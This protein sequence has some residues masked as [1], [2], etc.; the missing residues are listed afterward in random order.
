MAAWRRRALELFP[1]LRRELNDREYTVYLLFF[2][3]KP[4]LREAHD[5]GDTELLRRI[6][7]LAEWCSQ[8]SAKDLWNAA[9]VAF[10][11][12][13]FDYPAYSER[14][15]PWLSPRVVSTHWGLWEAMVSPDEWARVRPLLEGKRAAHKRKG[16]GL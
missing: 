2:D 13:L 11:E 3:L 8:Q 5:A 7:G 15:I 6:Y 1:Q 12:H 10:Y 9:G 14:V 4:L 16:A